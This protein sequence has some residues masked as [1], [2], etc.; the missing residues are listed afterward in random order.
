MIL[1]PYTP[2]ELEL[3]PLLEQLPFKTKLYPD[4]IKTM[5]LDLLI[6]WRDLAKET[7]SQYK[8]TI[9]GHRL[10]PMAVMHRI[11]TGNTTQT[12]GCQSCNQNPF[13]KRVDQLTVLIYFAEIRI[14]EEQKPQVM[15][16]T[17]NS[18]G[19]LN[20]LP[21]Y[22]DKP[23]FPA[24][25]DYEVMEDIF[26]NPDIPKEEEEMLSIIKEVL[27]STETVVTPPVKKTRKKRNG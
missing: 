20:I 27:D 9:P 3:R 26:N 21:A 14:L 19:S 17:T 11:L 25:I 4:I 22:E 12:H 23:A 2:L 7:I 15:A 6:R 13:K 18:D 10:N 5:D 8:H 16:I 24:T 1:T